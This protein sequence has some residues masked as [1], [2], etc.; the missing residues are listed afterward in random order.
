MAGGNLMADEFWK[1]PPEERWK[2]C[3][4]LSEHEAFVMR[5]TDPGNAKKRVYIPCN[6]CVHRIEKK[7]ACKAHPNGMTQEDIRAVI[8]DHNHDCGNGYKFEKRK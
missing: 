5:L 6:D 1:L 4:E 7:L 3:G 8:D 2:R